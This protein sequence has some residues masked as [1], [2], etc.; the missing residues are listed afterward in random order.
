[1]R[2]FGPTLAS[3]VFALSAFASGAS[4]QAQDTNSTAV[5]KAPEF[6]SAFWQ[7]WGDG[8]AELS[9]Y[10]ISFPRYGELRTGTAVAI[11]VTEPFSNEL[12]VK[13]DPG[14]HSKDDEFQVLKLNLVQDFP[15]GIYDYN[16]MT[17]VFV[18]L[19]QVNRL[20]SGS[21]TKVSFSSQEWCG[22]TYSQL[23]FG[24]SSLNYTL[25]SYFDREADQKKSIRSPENLLSEDALFH[26]A[27]GYAF[28]TLAPGEEITLPIVRSLSYSRLA[29]ADLTLSTV[30]LSTS[31][32]PVSIQAP[33][34]NFQARHLKAEIE[35][36]P[37]WEFWV[38]LD[39]P[40]L[41]YRWKAS[42]GYEGNLLKSTRLPYWQMN[43]E[44][45]K[46]AVK[47]LG[48]GE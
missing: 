9:G 26:W 35:N 36:G 1:M 30:K 4:A 31:D 23:L 6:P 15:T 11:F 27:R 45:Y 28:P 39:Y 5:A 22:H 18:A 19:Q 7:Y 25:H 10:K 14:V 38:G 3:I 40:H 41:L 24:T 47:E 33:A 8:K 32:Q 46:S 20:P 16:L 12:R 43:S 48:L 34:G 21:P 29:H 42:D 17:S 2:L 44:K 37:V 13:A